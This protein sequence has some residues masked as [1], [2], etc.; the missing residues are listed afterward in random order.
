MSSADRVSVSLTALLSAAAIA[1]IV[2]LQTSLPAE[3]A[4]FSQIY[5]FG[6]SLVDTGNTFAKTGIPPEPYFAG[7]F[8][9]GPI[10]NEY[11]ASDLN[12]A[13]TS[14]GFG[15]AL[16]NE[17][18]LVL[19]GGVPIA[20]V[21]GT[22][23]QVN[24]FAANPMGVDP[25]ALY[26]IWAGANDYFFAGQTNPLEPVG[27]LQEAVTI[28]SGAGAENF[29]LVN[30][31]D[32]GSLPLVG[33][34]GLPPETV[35]GLNALSSAHNQALA[36][37]VA[38]LNAG[39]NINVD[40]LDANG[41]FKS[42]LAGDLGFTNTTDACTLNPICVAD[43]TVQDTYLFW[44]EVH[45]TTAAHRVLADS[46]LALVHPDVAAVPEPTGVISLVL[47]GGLGLYQLSRRRSA[48]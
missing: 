11:L 34:R 15:G 12:V 37:T 32:L 5:A 33:L 4:G 44:D 23:S 7:R 29:L 48:S 38:G 46:A 47:V 17:A 13:E 2:A 36:A 6:D 16:S 41:L 22:L 35:A 3:A 40:L 30:L 45:P 14:L 39:D 20:P 27:N 31:P 24:S 26:V 28:L 42:A 9:N 1:P 10:W 43:P 18:G 21:P 25:N 8:S 19:F